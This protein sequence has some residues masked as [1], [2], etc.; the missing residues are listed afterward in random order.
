MKHF[1][2]TIAILA[3]LAGCSANSPETLMD[4]TA[5]SSQ[6]QYVLSQRTPA[7][8]QRLAKGAISEHSPIVFSDRY[9]YPVAVSDE[10]MA[11]GYSG[12]ATLTI[13]P[14]QLSPAGLAKVYVELIEQAPGAAETSSNFITD[15]LQGKETVIAKGAGDR[16]Y[17]LTLVRGKHS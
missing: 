11:E 10:G 7:G 12:H 15:V 14:I 13:A 1:L 16:E 6:V 4:S 2:I 9:N 8:Q 17:V 3:S 5:S